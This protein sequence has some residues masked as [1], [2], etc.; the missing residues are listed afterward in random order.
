ML[1]TCHVKGVGTSLLG[2]IRG[3]QRGLGCVNNGIERS[4]LGAS[5]HGASTAVSNR[6]YLEFSACK[7]LTTERHEQN[8]M[9][10]APSQHPISQKKTVS[11]FTHDICS[12]DLTKIFTSQPDS[13]NIQATHCSKVGTA[14]NKHYELT[15]LIVSAGE[16]YTCPWR[17]L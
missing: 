15:D 4:A 13:H 12:C 2:E 6:R 3:N 8:N 17:E 7:D 9:T 1:K 11:I 14:R 5:F 10:R 16:S